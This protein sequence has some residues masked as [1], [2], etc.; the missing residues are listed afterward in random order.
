MISVVLVE[1]ENAGNVGAVA[2]V[3]KN[4]GFSRLVLV[5]P[6]CDCLSEEARNRAKHAQDVLKGAKKVKSIRGFDSVIA[7]TAKLGTDY[8]IRRSPVTPKQLADAMPRGNIALVFGREGSGLTN[9]EISEC[10]FVVHIPSSRYQTFNI[11]HAVA[12]VLYELH[13]VKSDIANRYRVATEK[14]KGLLLKEV[15]KTIKS[16]KFASKEKRETQRTVWKRVLNKSFL[17]RREAYALFG[18][19][20]KL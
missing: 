14:E 2:R 1:P 5:N 9:E 17:T 7:T 11:S 3:S 4:F 20:R 13:M 8:N 15:E 19:F 10:D 18:F 6:K 16:M 12:I